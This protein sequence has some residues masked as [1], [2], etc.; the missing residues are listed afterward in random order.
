[1]DNETKRAIEF[2]RSTAPQPLIASLRKMVTYISPYE[3]DNDHVQDLRDAADWMEGASM[4][5]VDLMVD[6]GST[7][8]TVEAYG[9]TI[10]L[11]VADR[12]DE[13]GQ[14]TVRLTVGGREQ[15]KA[16]YNDYG[17]QPASNREEIS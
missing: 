1:M 8:K 6:E 5:V 12:V 10:V 4:L 17:D 3:L 9:R 15:H 7:T 14:F 2:A 16:N 11:E 13:Y